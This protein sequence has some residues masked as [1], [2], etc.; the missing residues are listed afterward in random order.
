MPPIAR[1]TNDDG[2]PQIHGPRVVG[3]TPARPFL[4][5][6]P[7]T[8]AGPLVYRA[9]GLPPGLS[10]N[11]QSGVIGGA[12]KYASLSLVKLEVSGPRGAA[13]RN[14]TI[15]A[16]QH[17]LAQTPPMGWNSWNAHGCGVT[18]ARVRAAA[19]ELVQTGLSRRGY[20]FVNVDDCWQGQRDA[21][22][23]IQSN[24]KF[25]DIGALAAYVHARGLK[26][27]IYSAPSPLT[28][29]GFAGSYGHEFEDAQTYARWGVDYL[30]YDYC[31]YDQ[32][33]QTVGRARYAAPFARMRQALDVSGRD[34]VYSI[35]EYGK[36]APWQWA[37]YAPVEANLWRT[38]RDVKGN[39][40]SVARTGFSADA[41]GWSR[42]GAWNDPDMLYLHPLSPPAQMTQMTL[43]SLR[44]APLLIGSDLSQLSPW[45]LDLLSN[46]EVIEVDQDPLGASARRVSRSEQSEVWA[47][48]LW[49]GTLAVGLFNR[50][51]A[52][53][54]VAV[55]WHDL[56]ITGAQ[57]VRDLWRQT[58]LGE[59]DEF[60][61]R[62]EGQGAVLVK[63]GAPKAGDY[64]PLWWRGG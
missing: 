17:Q 9:Q 48:R 41:L 29:A 4:F 34:I 32:V 8:G 43:W 56:G 37:G 38:S 57:R 35:S 58:D 61:A 11:A 36:S 15:V 18:G 12:V 47:R 5:Q 26:F 46:S 16:G 20:A 50:G 14:L 21:R 10:L 19:D 53:A 55:S 3:A 28:C 64:V 1:Q 2:P 24:A 27:G 54:R 7:A 30:K 60:A 6:I 44:G 51:K 42:P 23:Q 59:M 62:V 33:A 52:P 45:T 31:S 25:G 39:Y 49:D 63:V 40:G 13:S 22:G